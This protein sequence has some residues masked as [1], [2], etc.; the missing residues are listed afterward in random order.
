MPEKLLTL[1]ELS[2]YLG[3][4]EDKVSSLVDE[5]VITAYKIGGELLRFR[6]EQ[7]DAVRSEIEPRV[8]DSDKISLNET[9]IKVKERFK[10]SEGQGQSTAQERLSDFIYFNDFYIVSALIIVILLIVII[11][12]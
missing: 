12:G 11:R 3:I 5:G 4:K 10:I 2:Y 8:K 6:K 7:V 9:R 1:K